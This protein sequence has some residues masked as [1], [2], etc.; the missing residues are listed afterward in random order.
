MALLLQFHRIV[1]R[2]S[3]RF[4]SAGSS[5]APYSKNDIVAPRIRNRNPMN[6]EKM[7][8]G[9]KP[10]GFDLENK[11]R[12]YWNKLEL[13]IS[14]NH[15]TAVVTHW[16]GRVVAKAST[17]EWPIRQFLYNL[18]DQAALKVVGQVI[19]QRCLETGVSEVYLEVSEE[20]KEKEKMVKFIDVIEQSGLSLSEAEVYQP[21][22]PHISNH[23]TIQHKKVQPWTVLEPEN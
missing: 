1:P 10:R 7:L 6:L 16:T 15:T 9:K 8:I 5:D 11:S 23:R 18:T 13:E 2:I 3:V 14:N 17:M 20:D 19:S 12:N 22:N 4:Y 21:T